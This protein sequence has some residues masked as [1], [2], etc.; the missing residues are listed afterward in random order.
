[1]KNMYL[2]PERLGPIMPLC[3]NMVVVVLSQSVDST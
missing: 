1:M 2:G 3:G